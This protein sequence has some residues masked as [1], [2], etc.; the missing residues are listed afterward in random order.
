VREVFIFHPP[1][2]KGMI[3]HGAIALSLAAIGAFGIWKASLAVNGFNFLTYLLIALVSLAFIPILIYRIF[4][5]QRA[6]YT[7]ARDG[8]SL[9]WGLRREEIPIDRVSWVR[10]ADQARVPLT[11]PLLRLPGAVLGLRSYPGEKPVEYLAARN[12]RLVL[13]DTPERLYAISPSDQSEFLNTY[14]RL[15]E[16]GS[17][18]PIK[19]SSEYPTLLLSSVW[20]DPPARILLLASALMAL[21]LIIWVSATIP[22]HPMSALRLN[23]DGSPVELVPGIRLLLLPVLNI[24]FF[25]I[26]LLAGLLFYQRNETRALGYLMWASSALTTLLFSVAVF[27]ILRVT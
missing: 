8:I 18:A 20:A 21:G 27:N 25:I 17:L 24:F 6:R 1:R 9:Y 12:S 5:L 26:D 3:I 13:I 14:R 23:A 16:F 4:S 2:Q 7:L 22:S 10:A 11:K 19:S 15:A